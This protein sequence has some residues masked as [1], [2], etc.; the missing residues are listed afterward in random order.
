MTVI[1]HPEIGRMIDA[2]GIKTNLHD[3]DGDKKQNR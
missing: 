2:N 1:Q 3:V